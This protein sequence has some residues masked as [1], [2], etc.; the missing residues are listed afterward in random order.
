MCSIA[1]I[2]P[3]ERCSLCGKKTSNVHIFTECKQAKKRKTRPTT[4][5]IETDDKGTDKKKRKTRPT[6]SSIETDDKG[7]DHKK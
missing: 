7:T 5:S 2:G 6:T 4:S 3:V 1:P